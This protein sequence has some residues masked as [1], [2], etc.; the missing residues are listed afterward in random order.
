MSDF[1]SFADYFFDGVIAD[2]LVQNRIHDARNQVKD[3]IQ[4]VEYIITQLE[5][6]QA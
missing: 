4:K 5:H 2:W 3:A 1:V 6:Y